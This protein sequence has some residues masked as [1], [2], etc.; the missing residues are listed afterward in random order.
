MKRK[1]VSAS[2]LQLGMVYGGLIV[3]AINPIAGAVTAG[4]LYKLYKTR[5][6]VEDAERE[7]RCET[8]RAEYKAKF[9]RRQNF[10]SYEV[11]L[12]STLWHAKRAQVVQR[13]C[14]RCEVAGCTSSLEEVHHKHYPRVWGNEPIN[15]LIG[16]CAVHHREEHGS[17]R[18]YVRR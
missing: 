6:A 16:L 18:S 4:V 14:G 12:A 8:E 9:Y 11:Y 5:K 7:V 15:W 2:T 3:A 13:A 1:P 10:A 17:P